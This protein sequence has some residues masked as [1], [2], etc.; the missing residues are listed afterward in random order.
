MRKWVLL[1]SILT[2]F[3][4]SGCVNNLESNVVATFNPY[5]LM[6]NDLGVKSELLIPSNSNPHTYTP[7]IKDIQKLK[8]AKII[9]ADGFID[10]KLIEN[11][12]GKDMIIAGYSPHSWLD[13]NTFLNISKELRKRGFKINESNV[14]KAENILSKY[15]NKINIKV[16]ALHKFLKRPLSVY[17][18]NVTDELLT[19][20]DEMLSLNDIK[21]IDNSDACLVLV[22]N[23]HQKEML[24]GKIRKKI[25]V[26]DIMEID[27]G[28]NS[29]LDTM[30]KNLEGL[31][32]E[33]KRC[34][35]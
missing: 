22:T 23:K 30:E 13:I 26:L 3:L 2:L 32:E 5:K 28:E 20:E 19:S 8:N 31:Y 9:I 21:R 35:S 25:F 34:N 16:I 27:R 11:L 12:E 1:L 18:I 7:N 24:E 14:E 33:S 29:Y 17:G 15:R 6:L 10:K 4:I